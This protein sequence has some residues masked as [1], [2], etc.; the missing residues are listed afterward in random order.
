MC[1]GPFLQAQLHLP[2]ERHPLSPDVLEIRQI[3]YKYFKLR[4]GWKS[5]YRYKHGA[6]IEQQNFYKGEQRLH[7][8]YTY[9]LEGATEVIR[10]CVVGEKPCKWTKVYVDEE[11]LISRIEIFGRMDTL[12]ASVVMDQFVYGDSALLMSFVLTKY[13]LKMGT[14]ET[15][16]VSFTYSGDSTLIHYLR[17]CEE[18]E[19]SELLIRNAKGQVY[20]VETDHH[21]S[22]VVLLGGRSE[23]GKQRLYYKFDKRGNW[24]KQYYVSKKGKKTLEIKR[25]IK[26]A[27]N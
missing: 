6:I 12:R 27:G 20:T 16:C 19:Q 26:Y 18:L 2:F 22:T 5:L 9:A 11:D 10:Q 13:Y 1:V 25:K 24:V 8:S 17:G 21:D 14:S 15:N 7:E 3:H 23:E 4:S